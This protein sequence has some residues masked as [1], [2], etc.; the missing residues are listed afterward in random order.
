[1]KVFYFGDW[2]D[3]GHFLVAPNG[4]PHR[5][6]GPWRLVDL[7]AQPVDYRGSTGRGVVPEDPEQREGVWRL[8]HRDGW[9]AIGAWDRTGDA[10]SY[11]KAVFIAEGEHDLPAMERIA[12][13]HFPA[14][15][16]RI[17]KRGVKP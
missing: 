1:M 5:L 9:T 7:D 2:G 14:V 12:A 17:V 4:W 15:W 10:R 3:I 16:A 13:E 11:S 8:T 6:A